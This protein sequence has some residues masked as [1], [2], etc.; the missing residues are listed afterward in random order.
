MSRDL[1]IL[2]VMYEQKWKRPF[3][4]EY[5]MERSYNGMSHS[6]AYQAAMKS[7]YVNERDKPR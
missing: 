1:L 2:R 4:T 7:V 6:Q 3:A 5:I